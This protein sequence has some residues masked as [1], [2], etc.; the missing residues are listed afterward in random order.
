MGAKGL[1]VVSVESQ[2]LTCKYEVPSCDHT[3]SNKQ[4][5]GG[6][7]KCQVPVKI[8]VEAAYAIE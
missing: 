8:S 6:D 7:E 2:L 5:I 1:A 4:S 3:Y